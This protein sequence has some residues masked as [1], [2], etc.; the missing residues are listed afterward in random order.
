MLGTG[1][2][3][4]KDPDSGSMEKQR[5]FIL[6]RIPACWGHHL[7]KMAAHRP[8]LM[9]V[10]RI[11]GTGHLYSD[12]Q[13][14]ESRVWSLK[15]LARALVRSPSL[16]SQFKSVPNWH[17]AQPYL[18]QP[19]ASAVSDWCPIPMVFPVT[20]ISF[21]RNADLGLLCLARNQSLS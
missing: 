19:D 6:L 17:S 16:P 11:P 1:I 18:F 5:V 9:P 13:R 21:L 15:G 2:H 3:W 14:L 4:R 7:H 8:L 20:G 12:C 10:R